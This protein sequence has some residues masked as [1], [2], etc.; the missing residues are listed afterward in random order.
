MS[1]MKSRVQRA[2]QMHRSTPWSELIAQQQS[3]FVLHLLQSKCEWPRKLAAW[4][5]IGKR[6]VGRPRLRWDDAI[7]RQFA[8]HWWPTPLTPE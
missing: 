2:E 4:S 5:P 8:P 3:K 1:R 7:N 6:P